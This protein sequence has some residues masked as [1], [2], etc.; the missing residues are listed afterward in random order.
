MVDTATKQYTQF[1]HVPVD[2]VYLGAFN[3]LTASSKL[4]VTVDTLRFT[5]AALAPDKFFGAELVSPTPPPP[6]DLSAQQSDVDSRAATLAAGV[7]PDTVFQRFWFVHQPAAAVAI[8]RHGDAVDGRRLQTTPSRFRPTIAVSP[9]A[10]RPDSVIG[11]YWIHKAAPDVRSSA[12]NGGCTIRP[13]ASA[14]SFDFVQ[15]TGVFT[16]STFVNIGAATGGYMT[17]FDTSEGSTSLP[18]FSLFLQQ[19]GLPFLTVTGG[20]A[21]TVRFF[22]SAPAGAR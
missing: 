1:E 16:M 20:T 4:D 19:N 2:P 14:N 13:A 21:E 8:R 7:R 10:L 9:G 15:N 11:P 5:R 17:I 6:P 22:E 3:T 12:P 18:G